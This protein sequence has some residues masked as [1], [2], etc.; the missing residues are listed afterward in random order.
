MRVANKAFNLICV[1]WKVLC[2]KSQGT[3]KILMK[4]ITENYSIVGKVEYF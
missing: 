4:G 3:G 2:V 1:Y